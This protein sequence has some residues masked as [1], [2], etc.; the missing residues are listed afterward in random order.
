MVLN[1]PH[2]LSW[3]MLHICSSAVAPSCG[4][5]IESRVVLVDH[6]HDDLE[7]VAQLDRVELC[8]GHEHDGQLPGL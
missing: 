7:R 4:R 3:Q 2:L 1:G 8:R 6:E 5:P